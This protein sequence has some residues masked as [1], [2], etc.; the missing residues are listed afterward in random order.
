MAYDPQKLMR[1]YNQLLANRKEIFLD[2]TFSMAKFGHEMGLNRTYTS[3]FV[4]RELGGNFR[5]LVH[6]IRMEFA[7]EYLRQ[8]PD[9]T[10]IR[11]A[12]VTGFTSDTSFRRAYFQ[13]YGRK[14]SIS[15]I[16]DN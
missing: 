10:I 9:T 2:P 8:H 1:R 16:R 7:E 3:Q 13:H 11:L 15:E 12:K 5:S 4:N 6:K 14:L